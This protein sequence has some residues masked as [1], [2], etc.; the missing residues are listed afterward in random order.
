MLGVL[1]LVS[2]LARSSEKHYAAIREA[3]F[4]GELHVLLSH[5]SAGVRAKVCNLLGN[6]CRHSALFYHVL[7]AEMPSG[8]SIL[9]SLVECCADEDSVTRKFACF[10]LGNAAFHNDKL[11]PWL[12]PAIPRLLGLLRDAGEKTR[13]NAAGAVGNLVRNSAALCGELVR[14]GAVTQLVA[15]AISD[16]A[17]Q[18]RKIAL[19]SLG[20]LCVY[21]ECRAAIATLRPPLEER[22]RELRDTSDD[23]TISKYCERILSKLAARVVPS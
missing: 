23:A 2:Q 12:L 21:E 15:T 17:L 3:S 11:Y 7:V 22:M 10:A 1:G 16:A 19:F 13:A 9:A 5:P 20:N 14:A 6:L 18:P 8:G 4:E